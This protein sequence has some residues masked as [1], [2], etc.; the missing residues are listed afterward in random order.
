MTQSSHPVETPEILAK[1]RH[2]AAHQLCG[3][4]KWTPGVKAGMYDDIMRGMAD[5]EPLV[6]TA[7]A[8]IVETTEA[9]AKLADQYVAACIPTPIMG[10][11]DSIHLTDY[12]EGEKRAAHV[13][14]S[15]LRSGRHL[16]APQS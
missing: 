9:A 6:R 10:D 7:V 13:L 1:A 4:E 5:D 15:N 12:E 16:K 11:D 8:A 14:A 3:P 2:I